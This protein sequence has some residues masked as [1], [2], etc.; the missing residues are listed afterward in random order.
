MSK[1][2]IAAL[3]YRAAAVTLAAFAAFLPGCK[4]GG[5]TPEYNGSDPIIAG[6]DGYLFRAYTDKYNALDALSGTDLFSDG[7]L[8]GQ[9]SELTELSK[10]LSDKNCK[11]IFVF[12]PSKISVYRG[13]LPSNISGLYSENRRYTQLYGALKDTGE[14]VIDLYPAYYDLKDKEQL[15]H[16][17]ADGIN[18]LGGYRLFERTASYI[19]EKYNKNIKIPD[20]SD[21]ELEVKE[22]ISYPL[23]REYRNLTGVTVANK[24]V[25]LKEKTVLYKDAGYDYSST[26][27]TEITTDVRENGFDYLSFMLFHSELS[28]D[29]RKFFSASSALSVFRLKMTS[30][31]VITNRANPEFAVIIIS[32]DDIAA[33]PGGQNSLDDDPDVSSTP[34]I[35]ATA[36][37]DEKHFVIFGLSEKNSTVTVTGGKE[38]ISVYTKDG[39]FV[40]EV[41][42]IT[43][44]ENSKISLQCKTDGKK[45]ESQAVEFDVRYSK[46]NGNKYVLIGKDGHLHY[47]ETVPDF[48]GK[49]VLKDKGLAQQIDYI[50]EKADKI[51]DISPSTKII[52]VIAPSHLTIYPETAPDS[53]A[54]KKSDITRLT[55][56]IEA[57]RDNDKVTFIDLQTP[58]LS[59]KE[60]SPYLLYN[61]TDTHWN[62]LG[63]YYAYREI[64]NYISL[65]FP[66]A[67]PEPLDS[68]DVFT[69]TVAG[70]DMAKFL[71]VNL[72]SVTENCVFVRSKTEL[73]SGISKDYS[74]NFSNE[75]FSEK[76]EF[77]IADKD[78]P[79]MIMYRDSFS[80]NLMSF[81]AEKFSRSVFMEMWN[82]KD[83]LRLCRGIKPDYIIIEYAERN[84]GKQ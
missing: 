83:D 25:T 23:T 79:T 47:Q 50:T 36:Y 76:R 39:D 60:S 13:K 64:M 8:D 33:I 40:I 6:S 26:E 31:D 66:A 81:M 52:Y 2:K 14:D 56:F 71:E 82:Y 5:K 75:W 22:D 10:Q 70:G 48:T 54:A 42:I 78:L 51:H 45:Y 61:K 67:A 38:D 69:K 1:N 49:T 63:A 17:G 55:Q 46:D 16:T 53:V 41:P 12:V 19:N 11:N 62:E 77:R 37:S 20:I 15:Y 80:T 7:E 24:T 28:S 34:V 35:K 29:C 9:T 57:F 30:D 18:E 68:F 58:L 84:F 27:A 4:N 65:D 74:M 59:A 43:T 32:E 21:Y 72:D 3:L 44:A 73:K